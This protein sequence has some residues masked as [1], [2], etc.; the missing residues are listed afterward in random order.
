MTDAEYLEAVLR[1]QTLAAGSDELKEVQEHKAEVE[2][3]LRSE[4]DDAHPEIRYGGSKA[5]GTMIRESYDLDVICFFPHDEDGA[6]ETL[7][8]IYNNIAEKLSSKYSIERKPSAIRLH[9][10]DSGN[11]DFRIDVVPGRFI[12]DSKTDVWLYRSSGE[13]KRLKTNLDVHIEHV[14][15]SGVTDAIRLLKLW[16]VRNSVGVKNFALELLAVDLLKDRKESSL[17][18]Q[19]R[20]VLEQFRDHVDDLSIE[21]PANP[22]GNDLS[23]LLN[24]AVRSTLSSTAKSTL[25]LVDDGGWQKVFG[26][27]DGDDDDDDKTASLKRVAASIPAAS[28]YRP[29]YGG[30][31]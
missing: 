21:D 31:R 9:G 20:H 1:D 13:K 18:T 25:E 24:D 17:P 7:E 11:P 2:K 16:R 23:E 5:K 19:L 26:P 27:V 22:E 14:R 6:G 29:W 15:D 10:T 8:E 30:E 12:D 3:L 4:F 28:Q